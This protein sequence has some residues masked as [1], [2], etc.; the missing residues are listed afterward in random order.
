MRALP[1]ARAAL[2]GCQRCILITNHTTP[3]TRL[4]VPCLTWASASHQR[5]DPKTRACTYTPLYTRTCLPV[6]SDGKPS[7]IL[8]CA[9]HRT[10]DGMWE[11]C[12]DAHPNTSGGAGLVVGRRQRPPTCAT[13]HSEIALQGSDVLCVDLGR[14][15][16]ACR[17]SIILRQHPGGSSNRQVPCVSGGVGSSAAGEL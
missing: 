17:S 6:S 12:R 13:W 16:G 1:E 7:S 14:I 10:E 8:H 3:R 9:L 5:R 11:R 4:P 2:T 15:C